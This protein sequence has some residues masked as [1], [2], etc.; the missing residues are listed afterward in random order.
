MRLHALAL[1]TAMA[2]WAAPTVV[3]TMISA[4]SGTVNYIEGTALID[5]KPIEVKYSQFPQLN[6]NSVLRTT[7][8]GR[9]EVLLADGIFLR[10][11]EGSAVRMLSNR[12]SETRL[13]LL[14][15]S[16]LI[17]WADQDKHEPLTFV[18]K[19]A[20]VTLLK[21]GVYRLDAASPAGIRVYDGEARV[22]RDGQSA[23]VKRAKMLA[24]E[25]VAVPEKFDNKTG[26]A[27][28]RWARRRAEYL[29]YAN[30]NAAKNAASSGMF[31]GS[32]WVYNPWFGMFTWMPGAGFYNSF[33]GYRYFSPY[34]VYQVYYPQ[35]YTGTN[36][37]GSTSNRH[38]VY[39]SAGYSGVAPTSA[40][41][42]GTAARVSSSASSSPTPSAPSAPA[43]SIGPGHAGGV[44][45]R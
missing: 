14:S 40:G 22:T 20:Q 34:T 32:G 24:L 12:L 7:D 43:P 38:P 29:S 42:S 2:A 15:G 37:G 28:F 4:K 18:V 11:G 26:D 17:E 13:E 30:I 36:S 45:G 39:S 23:E 1:A 8:E 16:A 10:L 41:T 9:V 25:G 31:A 6:N 27:L 5:E 33:W 3:Q 19:D 44:R 21:R 35:T